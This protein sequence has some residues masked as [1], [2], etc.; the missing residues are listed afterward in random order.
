LTVAQTFA[1][2]VASL[3]AKEWVVY[4]KPPIASAGVVLKYL[5]RY[6]HRV[7]LS[8]RRLLALEDGQVTFA[9]KD[10][11]AGGR[12][13][14][15]RLSAAE[16]LRRWLQHVLPVGFV[17]VRHYGLLANRR[18]AAH[19]QRCRR[20]LLVV[21][22]AALLP[23]VAAWAEQRCPVCGGQRWLVVERTPRPKVAQVCLLPL[24]V[25]TS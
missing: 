3:Q 24:G 20:L 12:Q 9:Y 6:T 8:N 14:T 19:L 5:A 25:D 22:A 23:G 21:A 18:R 11:A 2:L 4:S 13:K 15:L 16:F 7:A 17:K 10:Y 1:A